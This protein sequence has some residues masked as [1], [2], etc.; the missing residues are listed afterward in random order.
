M[1]TIYGMKGTKSVPL[2]YLIIDSKGEELPGEK[3]LYKQDAVKRAKELTRKEH[4]RSLTF[5]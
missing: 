4:K 3:F 2:H 1:K 5:V